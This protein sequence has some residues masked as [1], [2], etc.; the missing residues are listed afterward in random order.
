[1]VGISKAALGIDRPG[2]M[3]QI[4]TIFIEP[5]DIYAKED[6]QNF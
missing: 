3:R 6:I 4:S 5:A 2:S 1:V